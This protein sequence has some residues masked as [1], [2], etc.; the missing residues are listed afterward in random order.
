[1]IFNEIYNENCLETMYRMPEN[2]IDMALT[3]PPYDDARSYD[4]YSFDFEYIAKQLY[5]V[6]K[7]GGVLVWVVGDTVQNGSESGTSFKQALYFKSIGF[8]LHDT[9]IYQKHNFS[10]P[11][12]TRYHQ[13]FEYMFIFSKGAPKTFN[14]IIDRPNICAGQIGSWGKNTVT[15]TDGSKLERARKVNSEMGMRYNIWKYQ[16]GKEK[17]SK[18]HPAVFPLQLAIDHIKS[19]S[20][21]GDLIYDPFSGSGTTMEACIKTN[22]NWIMSEVNCKYCDVIRYRKSLLQR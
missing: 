13:I 5:R 16:C 2:Y 17:W 20:N 22:R 11:S 18:Y 14:P 7:P 8:N 3:S 4:G 21:E 6:T 19:W 10:N 15:Q 1:M 9:M 12:K